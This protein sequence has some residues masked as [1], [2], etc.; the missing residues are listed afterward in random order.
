MSF[1]S[2]PCSALLVATAIAG[3]CSDDGKP[4]DP[5]QI[6]HNNLCSPKPVV[7]PEAGP[8]DMPDAEVVDGEI[9]DATNETAPP[10]GMFGKVCMMSGDSPE[11]AEPAPY[12]AVQP[13]GTMG[14]CTAINCKT[15]PTVCPANWTCFDV[16]V[17]NFCLKP[18][19]AL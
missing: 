12:C 3:G 4:C 11:C 17:L 7:V 10:V 13:G 9:T 1:R 16:G 18:T 14:Y 19:T 6:Y 8:P 15:N 5:N 2:L